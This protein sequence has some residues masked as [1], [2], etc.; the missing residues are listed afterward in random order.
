MKRLLALIAA[1]LI[2]FTPA[3][4]AH[5]AR[6]SV[7][8]HDAHWGDT[9]TVMVSRDVPVYV[10]CVQDDQ[11][12]YFGLRSASNGVATFLLNPF[13]NVDLARPAQCVAAAAFGGASDAFAVT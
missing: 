6:L 9:E 3:S 7:Q 10:K 2:L 11:T 4:P 1:A 8:A 12:V 5:A 13:D